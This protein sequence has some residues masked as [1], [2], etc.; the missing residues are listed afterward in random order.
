V[1]APSRSKP[2]EGRSV[3]VATEADLA[4]LL[5]L[6]RAY[7]DFYEKAPGDEELLALSRA[8][9]ADPEQEGVQLI[10]RDADGRALGFATIFWSW[11][12]TAASRIGIMNDLYVV[13]GARGS[14]L[15]E[16][17]IDACVQRCARRG[18]GELEWQTAP[19]N[20]RAQAVY[21]R[22]GGVREQWINYTLAVSGERGSG[23]E[24]GED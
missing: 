4:D 22:C 19:S 3:T 20:L 1:S 5:P 15:A 12:T 8:L 14:G 16:L 7:C 9:I 10:A 23:G 13:P 24:A 2:A 11:S 6:M 17:L 18:A 21:D